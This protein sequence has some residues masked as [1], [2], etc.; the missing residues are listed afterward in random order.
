VRLGY[1]PQIK[2]SYAVRNRPEFG[3]VVCHAADLWGGYGDFEG[4]PRLKRFNF[5]LR[6]VKVIERW[7]NRVHGLAMAIPTAEFDDIIAPTLPDRIRDPYFT[8]LLLI[9]A[10]VL[11][12][13]EKK[14][15]CS[16]VT[17]FADQK[18]EYEWRGRELYR[19]VREVLGPHGGR[20]DEELNYRSKKLVVPL[21]AADF[22][23]HTA[24]KDLSIGDAGDEATVLVRG[25]INRRLNV[26][27]P[28]FWT[29]KQAF[30]R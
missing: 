19:S 7:K 21:Q 20:L 8:L 22:L 29:R 11:R 17:C 26:V 14:F 5:A 3:G 1:Y 16:M 9:L 24:F 30:L 4:W 18:K 10:R 6:L 25:E 28:I 27:D 23:A 12:M 2:L 13:V 15:D